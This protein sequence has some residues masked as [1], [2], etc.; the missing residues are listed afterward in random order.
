MIIIYQ[1]YNNVFIISLV[2]LTLL[3]ILYSLLLTYHNDVYMSYH[4]HM[5]TQTFQFKHFL[6]I[7][8]ATKIYLLL[9]F[10]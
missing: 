4:I 1:S 2:I 3:L 9:I 8:N 5:Y 6:M 7:I 10:F